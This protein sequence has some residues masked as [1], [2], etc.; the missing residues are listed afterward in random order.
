MEQAKA[1]GL[2]NEKRRIKNKAEAKEETESIIRKVLEE[3]MDIR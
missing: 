2:L 3:N 1:A